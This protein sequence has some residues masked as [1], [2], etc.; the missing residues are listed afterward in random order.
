MTVAPEP[1][2]LRVATWNTFTRP[3][4]PAP[5]SGTVLHPVAHAN[6]V[7]A[8]VLA[9]ANDIDVIA[10]NEVGNEES[11]PLIVAGLSPTF[12]HHVSK[13]FGNGHDGV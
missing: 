3:N 6:A 1:H 10:L 9:R 4:A 12:T 8:E 7:V 11:R 13:I 5:S 2:R